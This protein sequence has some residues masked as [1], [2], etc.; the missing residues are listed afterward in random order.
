[1][2]SKTPMSAALRILSRRQVS[3]GQMKFM[4]LQKQF[5]P[6]QI[7]ECI[8]KLE[9]WGYIDDRSLAA[10]ILERMI[11]NSPCG[12]KRC[13]YEL[14]KRRFDRELAKE[15]VDRAYSELDE[16]ALAFAAAEQYAKNKSEMASKDVQRLAGWLSRRGFTGETIYTV[17]RA[18]SQASS[19]EQIPEY[20]GPY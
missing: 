18:Y 10:D 15:L 12:K 16:R 17:I 19:G 4:L 1:M 20:W 7:D 13:L 6:Q 3:S 11:S 9:Q 5:L 2:G 14:E 8:D